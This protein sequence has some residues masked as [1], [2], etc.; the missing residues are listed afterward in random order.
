MNGNNINDV[1]VDHE[2]RIWIANYPSGITIRDN[3]Y[4]GY[5]WTRHS[6]GNRQSLVNNQVHD[7]IEDSEGDLWFGTS[8]GISL[9]SSA[10]GEWHSFFSTFDHELEDGFPLERVAAL[11]NFVLDLFHTDDSRYEQAGRDRRDRHHDRV[12][13][14]IKEV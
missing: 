1:H 10:T 13:Q 14:E 2:G 6:V 5:R 8:N 12:C 4:S 9:Y 7:V 11:G 3:R